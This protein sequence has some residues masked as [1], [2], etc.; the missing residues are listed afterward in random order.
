VAATILAR[1]GARVLV[2]D[3]A[4][5][6]RPKVC[7]DT[8]NPGAMAVLRR[9]GLHEGVARRGVKLSGMIVTGR[10]GISVRG[11]YVQGDTAA[12]E[13]CG[14]A[15]MR[16]EL[17]QLLVS[18]AAEAGARVEEGVVIRGP[19]VRDDRHGAR[20]EGVVVAGRDGQPVAMRAAVTIAADG[21]TS[22]V[23]SALGLIAH[24]RHPRRWVVNGYFEGVHG[25]SAYGEMHI[26]GTH[27][28]GVA[29]LP[30]GIA[31]VCY[32]ARPDQRL[33]DPAG[34]LTALVGGDAMLGDRFHAARLIAMPVSM[35][36]LAVDARAAGA[37]G[38]LLAGDAAG[39]IDPM[40]GDGLR[41]ALRGAELAADAAL[42]MLAASIEEGHVRLAAWRAREFGI[43][44]RVGR[45]LRAWV[46]QP[47]GVTVGS[48][49][50]AGVPALLRHLIV[51]ASDVD[52]ARP[53][54]E[55][56]ETLLSP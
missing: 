45:V 35:G 42:E 32:V 34:L 54:A 56:R 52:H 40:T 49:A 3:R 15:I 46:G 13:C 12:D 30:G 6:P 48:I 19:L 23:A 31:N 51:Y 43:K 22:R 27:Y 44:W 14:R 29:P 36:P 25:L 33:A 8:L 20:V 47:A 24:P 18:A 53:G 2:L 9:L 7:G 39:F 5:F 1:A 50:A 26:R 10:W 21:R 11:D 55:H 37:R 41:F 17:D 38:L 28:L 4:R 16:R